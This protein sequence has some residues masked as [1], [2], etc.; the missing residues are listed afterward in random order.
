MI[1]TLNVTPLG[2][3]RMTQ[4]DVW[5]KR[6]CVLRYRDACDQLRAEV[7]RLQ[8]VVPECDFGLSFYLPIPRS[9]SKKKQ[10]EMEGQPHQQRPDIDN[11]LKFFLDA[12]MKEDCTVW[13]IQ[14]LRKYWSNH[15]R[16]EITL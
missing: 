6:P 11:C 1:Y 3:P 10:L 4:R 13:H 14:E 2:K 9:W 16:I 8:L 12:L 7:E 15:P 5:K